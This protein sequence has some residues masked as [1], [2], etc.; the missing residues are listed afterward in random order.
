MVRCPSFV[1]HGGASMTRRRD[2]V[3]VRPVP[4]QSRSR[5]AHTVTVTD[6]DPWAPKDPLGEALH[7][8]R[9]SGAYYC[10]S[11]LSAP[12][13]LDLPAMNGYMWFHVVTHGRCW[14]ET[15]GSEPH[16]LD[17]G[18]FALVPHGEGHILRS[19]PTAWARAIAD[20]PLEQVS[21]RYEVLRYGGGGTPTTMI[22][23]AVR[24]DHPAAR[25][26]VG[27]MPDI[28]YLEPPG[29][30]ESEWM[31]MTLRLIAT[32]AKA[33][34]PGGE[35]MITRLCDVLIVQAIRA[36]I[37]DDNAARRGWIGALHDPQIGR[38]ISLVH[39]DP[40]RAW[41]VESLAH[42]VALSR[43]AFASRFS[44]LVGESP[45]AYV[46]R[47]RMQVARV[48][49]SEADLTVSQVAMR[50]GYGSEAAFN[51]AFKRIVG[52]P[53]GAVKAARKHAEGLGDQQAV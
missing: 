12:W 26:L 28:I 25:D 4:L 9:M 37:S 36:W 48:W 1:R 53:P 24:F 29:S 44:E 16:L 32:E 20:V 7:V 6:L 5:L 43:S 21:D 19:E 50:L 52:V 22:C 40:A 51:R 11:E 45:M 15:K 10:R 14:L 8:L 23:G 34:R 39:R 13:G 38:A 42:E 41:T 49:L 46:T 30:L 27:L 2:V 17:P 33:L 3:I 31:N 35:T 18:A 47:W